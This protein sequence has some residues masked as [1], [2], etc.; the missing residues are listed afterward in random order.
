M[1]LGSATVT[2][3]MPCAASDRA[4]PTPIGPPPITSEGPV[5]PAARASLTAC[6]PQAIGSAS[7]AWSKRIASGIATRLPSGIATAGAKAPGRG[8]IEMI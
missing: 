7:A 6:Q 1:A 3:A 2:S 4:A 8:G 5:A